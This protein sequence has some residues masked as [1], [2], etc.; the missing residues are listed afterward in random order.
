MRVTEVDADSILY[1]DPSEKE[2]AEEKVKADKFFG[3]KLFDVLGALLSSSSSNNRSYD[4]DEE[5]EVEPYWAKIDRYG[6]DTLE[7]ELYG[8]VVGYSYDDDPVE[9][10][11]VLTENY[12]LFPASEIIRFDE[13]E[14]FGLFNH[15]GRRLH[16]FIMDRLGQPYDPRIIQYGFDEDPDVDDHEVNGAVLYIVTKDGKLIKDGIDL[17]VQ[18]R[19]ELVDLIAARSGATDLSTEDVFE[20][21]FDWSYIEGIE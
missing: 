2:E 3:G 15:C 10:G 11:V 9:T 8:D 17:E 16:K 4:D 14:K 21:K 1:F 6:R 5:E 13:I 7:R 18:Y 12:I 19:K 20:G